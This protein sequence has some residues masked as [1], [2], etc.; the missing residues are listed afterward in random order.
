M[1]DRRE[2]LVLDHSGHRAEFDLRH[3]A[4]LAS[5]NVDGHELLVGR[6]ADPM[7]WGSYPMAPW[8]GRIR[9]GRFIY[10][11]IDHQ[12]PVTLGPHAIHGTAYTSPWSLVTGV[13]VLEIDDPWPFPARLEQRADL[14]ADGL[15][16]ELRVTAGDRSMP[17]MLGW[18][19]WFR[20]V[21][22]DVS[23]E[24]DFE[25]SAM[26]ELDDEMIPTGRVVDPAE[27]P[28]DNTF[29][30]MSHKPVLRWPGVVELRLESDCS[31][32]TVYTEPEHAVCVEPQT[33]AP[34]IFNRIAASGPSGVDADPVLQPGDS[35]V[36]TFDLRW[37]VSEAES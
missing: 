21:I 34:D 33:A 30:E 19:P 8:A 14:A 29:T 13:M 32:W 16:I 28:W 5:L 4:R 11:G 26:F 36:A 17:A 24:L 12:L 7:R 10:D 6:D 20:R 9:H 1:S 18:H 27:P 2:L 23:V 37:T 3:G 22:A 31:F 35:M 15:S 25:A